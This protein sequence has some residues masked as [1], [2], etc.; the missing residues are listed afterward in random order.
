M[1]VERKKAIKHKD[2]ELIIRY[3][4]NKYI[5]IHG[6]IIARENK[7]NKLYCNNIII[8]KHIL[9][10]YN[11]ILYVNREYNKNINI[12]DIIGDRTSIKIYNMYLHVINK[13]E[14]L[15]YLNIFNDLCSNNN[16]EYNIRNRN[17]HNNNILD[18]IH[19][20][21]I[22][23]KY[24]INNMNMNNKYNKF[25]TE[26]NNA[27]QY[28]VGCYVDFHGYRSKRN[29]WMLKVTYKYSNIKQE[30]LY[31]NLLTYMEYGIHIKIK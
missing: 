7:C 12:N 5:N 14:Y 30:I 18:T 11:N 20:N 29:A 10:L 2:K 25:I 6:K 27:K 8:L 24:N 1:K 17:N 26:I 3:Y 28:D 4:R 15:R 13:H 16:C 19:H 31:Q 22:H 23:Y 9:K 21:I